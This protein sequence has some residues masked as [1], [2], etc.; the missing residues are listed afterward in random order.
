MA[1]PL[2]IGVIFYAPRPIFG[3]IV[4]A[5]AAWGLY[6]FYTIC[7]PDR[8]KLEKILAVAAGS[9][10]V[11]LPQWQESGHPWAILTFFF[12]IGAILFLC[13]FQ[14]LSTAVEEFGLTL[15]GFLYIP[16]LL[17]H[18]NLLLDLSDGRRWIF[19]TLA[20]VMI[21][22]SAA[23]FV[24]SALGRHR[25][26]PAISPKKS[27]EGLVGGMVGSLVAVFLAKGFFFS[28]LQPTDCLVLGVLLGTLGPLGDLFESMIKRSYK[29]KDSGSAIPGHGGLLDRLDSLLFSFPA[30]YY[31]ARLALG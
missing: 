23:Y 29:V 5:L 2:I 3:G 27:W 25:L 13:R 15:L 9:F 16:F 24:G 6:E 17:G 18:L 21:N 30:V 4:M 1:I 12:T 28:S 19:L 10:L 14:D 8:R 20:A 26:Y 22:D 31:Y 11:W 7:L